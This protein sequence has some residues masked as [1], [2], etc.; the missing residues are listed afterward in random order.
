MNRLRKTVFLCALLPALST[1][2]STGGRLALADIAPS[3][4]VQAVPAAA[5]PTAAAAPTAAAPAAA[6]PG[7]PAAAVPSAPVPTANAP[8]G[9]DKEGFVPESRMA[10]T[11]SVESGIPAPTLVGAAYGFIWLA[12]M[13]FVIITLLGTRAL[14]SEIQRLQDR[15]DTGAK[16]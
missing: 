13:A 5:L 14:E 6:A 11:A 1:G 4:E 3:R 16:G 10:M 8:L 12:V 9:A 15:L 2:F 7:T